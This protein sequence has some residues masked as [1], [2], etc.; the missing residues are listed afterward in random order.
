MANVLRDLKSQAIANVLWKGLLTVESLA[1]TGKRDQ[2]AVS[3]NQT[4][5]AFLEMLLKEADAEV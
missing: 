1:L 2:G 3:V 5:T 4:G